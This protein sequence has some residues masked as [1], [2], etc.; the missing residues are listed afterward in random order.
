MGEG[1][2][3]VIGTSPSQFSS[4]N[5]VLLIA[6]G[7]LQNGVPGDCDRQ[8]G[9][10]LAARRI[11]RGGGGCAG[12]WTSRTPLRSGLHRQAYLHQPLALAFT[13]HSLSPRDNLLFPQDNQVLDTNFGFAS[14]LQIYEVRTNIVTFLCFSADK[15]IE[16]SYFTYICYGIFLSVRHWIVFLSECVS[17]IANPFV[18][19]VQVCFYSTKQVQFNLR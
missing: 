13:H 6:R 5:C 15:R 2:K 14:Q 17:V 19:S 4:G 16:K 3:T 7:Q 11:S 18:V 8:G 12:K 9:R 10:H 1:G